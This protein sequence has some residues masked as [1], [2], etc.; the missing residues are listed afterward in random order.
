MEWKENPNLADEILRLLAEDMREEKPLPHVVELIYC[1]TRSWD[2]RNDYI[3]LSP[4]EVILFTVGIGL[5]QTLLRP[6]RTEVRGEHEGIHYSVDFIFKG[7]VGELK[8][9]RMALKKDP[10]T[11]PVTWTRQIQAYMKV[12]HVTEMVVP[13]VFVI[14]AELKVWEVS[15]SVEEIDQNWSWLQARRAIYMDY[16]E[17]GVRPTPFTYNESWECRNC[18]YKLICETEQ[19]RIEQG[20]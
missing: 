2:D 18:R 1:L 16:I 14:P 4:K 7:R 9:T 17:R 11:Y 8:S 19:M 15:S 20:Q 3:P 12:R 10:K 6:H 5:G 13:V